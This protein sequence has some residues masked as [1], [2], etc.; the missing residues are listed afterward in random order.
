[1]R[2]LDLFSGIGG[3]SLGIERAGMNT[4]A[5]CEKDLLCK[6]VL[7]KHWPLVP[8]FE[9]ITKLDGTKFKGIDLICGGF[10]CQDIS[11]AGLK[12]G[13]E[14]DGQKTRSGLWHEYKRIIKEAQPRWVV[15]ENVRNLLNIGLATVLKDLHEV[16]YDAEWEVISA[17]SVGACHLRERIWIVAYPSNADMPRFWPTFATTEEKSE[18]WTKATACFRDW[19][20]TQSEFCRMDDGLPVGL[21]EGERFRKERIKQ[22][23]NSIVPFIA[24]LIGKRIMEIDL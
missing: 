16:G 6:K 24:E 8:V 13:L 10:P 14:Y 7:N 2:V 22:L 23:G 5:F 12:K 11:V 20:K 4:I 1:M 18:R 9:D 3:F 17:R 15:I 19:W 21:D